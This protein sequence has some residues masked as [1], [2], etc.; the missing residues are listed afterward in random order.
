MDLASFVP[1]YSGVAV[2]DSHGVPFSASSHLNTDQFFNYLI[3]QLLCE[4]QIRKQRGKHLFSRDE[5]GPVEKVLERN[6]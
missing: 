5:D 3:P 6:L 1:D 4:C 2:P